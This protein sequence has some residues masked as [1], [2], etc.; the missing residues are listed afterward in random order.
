MR[1]ERGDGWTM[2]LTESYAW[3]RDQCATPFDGLITDPPY[4]SGGFTRSDRA[5]T[6]ASKYRSAD[7]KSELPDFA[8]DNRDQRSFLS[9]AMLWLCECYRLLKPGAPAAMFTDWRQLPVMS[10]AFQAGGF[11][12][13]G[14]APWTKRS[15]SR[16]QM[17]RFRNDAEYLVWGS[18]GPL[19]QR[20]DV[21][22][23]PGSWDVAPVTSSEREHITEKPVEVMRGV[24]AIVP[25]GGLVLDPFA[26]SASTGI[27]CLQTGRSFLGLEQDPVIFARAVERLRAHDAGIS[28]RAA[29]A[30][31]TALFGGGGQ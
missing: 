31:Q 11:V 29:R 9:W 12:W 25:H 3:L 4:S 30:G 18:R 8:G 20:T 6:P 7:A 22:V 1:E 26:G 28:V 21:G 14:V 24:V 15:A 19:P 17:G 13:R 16:P 5:A 10:D 23:L 27:A 2:I